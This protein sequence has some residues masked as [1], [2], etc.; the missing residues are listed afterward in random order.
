MP[1]RKSF[2]HYFKTFY[3]DQ[4]CFDN[5]IGSEIILTNDRIII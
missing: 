3:L 2:N 4:C 1:A 5:T